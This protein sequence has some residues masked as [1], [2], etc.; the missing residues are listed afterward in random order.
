[1]TPPHDRLVCV[2]SDFSIFQR[3]GTGRIVSER[4]G[5]RD[6]R[7]G[8]EGGNRGKYQGVVWKGWPEGNTG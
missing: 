5:E 7:R 8:R 6:R 1:M 3:Q 4:E 2:Y